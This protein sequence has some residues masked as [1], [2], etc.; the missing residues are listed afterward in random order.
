MFSINSNIFEKY[1]KSFNQRLNHTEITTE[2]DFKAEFTK[3]KEK[4]ITE[5]RKKMMKDIY[6][7]MFSN[8]AQ[9]QNQNNKNSSN[10]TNC[11]NDMEI[12]EENKNNNNIFNVNNNINEEKNKIVLIQE[13]LNEEKKLYNELGEEFI[14]QIID[15]RKISFCPS[16]GY[17]VIIID[18]NLSNKGKDKENS[19]YISIACVNSCFQFELNE[20]VFNKYSMDNI[21]DLYIQSMK[22]DNDCHHNDIAPI[23]SGDDEIV[24][25]CISCLVEQLR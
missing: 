1:K 12:E 15:D 5:R 10:P 14:Y 11:V 24:F 18:K 4:Q 23:T 17:P 22:R 13:Y 3:K 9:K 20:S 19:E 21:M 25:G 6:T 8:S 7:K 2:E 16:C